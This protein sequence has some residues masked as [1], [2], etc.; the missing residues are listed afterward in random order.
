MAVNP[1]FSH[2]VKTEQTLYEDIIIE[3][4]QMYGQDVV[5]MPRELT[6]KDTIFG[7]DSIS[8][9]SKSYKIEAYIENL[10]GFDG[11]G[12]LFTKFGV[13]IRD[14]AS[15]V[16][17]RRRWNKLVK[18]AN[19]DI[20]FYRPREGDLIYLP[21][22]KS[23]FEITK[24]DTE[25]PFFQL[26]NLPVFKI[27]AS[28]FEYNDEDFDTDTDADKVEANSAYKIALSIN[29]TPS[30][31]TLGEQITQTFASGVIMRG[32]LVDLNDSDGIIYVAHIGAD[33]GKYHEFTTLSITGST[34]LTT[35]T[36]T[37]VAEQNDID[38]GNQNA[39]FDGFES[40]FIDFSETN[41][42]GD[43]S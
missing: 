12:D 24:V 10:E 8:H 36:V 7:D 15:F 33:D 37:A 17:S 20:N 43:P 19:N 25:S 11:E 4:L 6:N 28:L 3:S 35:A 5:Y 23:T 18:S 31:F 38:P 29:T 16:I 32:E 14:E 34:S 39:I 21:L 40:E 41:P 30:L 42:F 27:R 1:Y 13:E 22:S 9:F 26:K 2:G